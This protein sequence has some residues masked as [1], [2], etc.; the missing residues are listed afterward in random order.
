MGWLFMSQQFDGSEHYRLKAEDDVKGVLI[1]FY[2]V[3]P[4]II[5]K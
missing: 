3:L 2:M 4:S 5:H 1:K